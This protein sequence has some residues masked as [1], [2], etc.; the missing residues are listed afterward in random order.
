MH[1]KI[2]VLVIVGSTGSGK[3][4]LGI[5]LARQYAGVIIAADSRTVYRGMDVGTAK[6]AADMDAAVPR[7]RSF[8]LVHGIP[9]Y[10]LDI[11][12][13]D[14][15]YSAAEF[16]HDAERHIRRIARQGKLPI[17][18]GG[19]GL[20]VE[21]VVGGLDFPDVPP[22]P[23]LRAMLAQRSLK[24]LGAWYARLDP[25]GWERI[26][27]ANPRRLIRALEV[28]LAT[29]RP[30]SELRRRRPTAFDVLQIGVDRSPRALERRIAMRA[31]AMLRGGLIS[32]TQVLLTRYGDVEPLR[33]MGYREVVAW[34][35]QP[36]DRRASLRVLA[37][38]IARSMERYARKQRAWFRR[39]LTVH[40]VRFPRQAE[41]LV[42]V[43]LVSS[44]GGQ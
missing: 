3:T 15:S 18:V 34:L 38:A 44:G 29:G 13:P 7:T 14:E 20:Y 2:R 5:S 25:V 40:W 28:S 33:G 27:R 8:R 21:A 37:R 36:L 19:T 42:R 39:D 22:D 6:P 31:R 43:F 10:G 23:A 24:E 9:H 17:V 41:R 1:R 12:N 16:V 30:F 4:D 35:Q 32:E 26:D 11:R